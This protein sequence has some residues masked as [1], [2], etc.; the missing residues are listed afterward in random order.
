MAGSDELQVRYGHPVQWPVQRADVVE[1]MLASQ[2]A[3]PDFLRLAMRVA[4]RCFDFWG[5]VTCG[6]RFQNLAGDLRRMQ[7]DGWKNS[8]FDFCR[9][10]VR[11]YESLYLLIV[12]EEDSE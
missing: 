9:N 4:T 5:L 3:M 7:L 11:F 1:R 10:F 12:M 8:R 6:S 2:A